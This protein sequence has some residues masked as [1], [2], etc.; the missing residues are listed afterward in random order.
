MST[1]EQY[2]IAALPFSSEEQIKLYNQTVLQELIGIYDSHNWNI[3]DLIDVQYEQ[4]M[5]FDFTLFQNPYIRNE[6]KFYIKN[7]LS[8]LSF[9]DVKTILNYRKS[10]NLISR[11]IKQFYPTITSITE[12]PRDVFVRYCRSIYPTIRSSS[13][14]NHIGFF[15]RVNSFYLDFYDQRLEVDKDRWSAKKLGLDY[16]KTQGVPIF[17]FSFFPKPYKGLIKKYIYT[18]LV[19][20]K[21]VSCGTALGYVSKLHLFFTFIS[22]SHP[23]WTNLNLLSRSDI[24]GFLEYIKKTPMGGKNLYWNTQKISDGHIIRCIS[25]LEVFIDYI[26]RNEFI[27][28]PF[29]NLK[30]L[31][32][33]GDKPKQQRPKVDKTKY[34]PDFIWN[35]ITSKIHL[36]PKDIVIIILLLECTGFRISDV[37]TL[38]IDCLLHKEDGY[39]ITGNQRKVD[40]PFHKVP[41]TLEIAQIIET[42]KQYVE[43]NYL[44]MKIHLPYLFLSFPD[45]RKANLI[46]VVQLGIT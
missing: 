11:F 39:W 46:L 43:K 1:V 18:R 10:F 36:L 26:Q 25:H 19:I 33:P 2:P 45:Q 30:N 27:E 24:I 13:A 5:Y 3:S 20:Q 38:K 40:D 7:L 37:L 4:A 6:I 34:I 29:T 16:N 32:Y 9:D 42:Q 35:Q 12:I 31:I 15:S 21:S 41:I 28:A 22:L 17:D 23:D 44:S 14:S 8:L